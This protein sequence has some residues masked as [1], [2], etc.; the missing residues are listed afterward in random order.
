[1]PTAAPPEGLA[2]DRIPTPAGEALVMWD[3]DQSLR[4][5]DWAGYEP[6]MRR[7]LERHYGPTEPKSAPAPK[8]LK[9]ALTGYFDG[10][11]K[12]SGRHRLRD[13]RHALPARGLGGLARHPRRHDTELRRPGAAHRQAG[14]GAGGGPGQ[15]RQPDRPGRALPSGDQRRR[16]THRLRWRHRAQALAA[17][18]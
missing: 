16:L 12:S 7:L 11:L 9:D 13:R 17:A 2:F 14:G 4:V 8:P 18:P 6:R 3:K 5:F 10:D 15:R 1:M